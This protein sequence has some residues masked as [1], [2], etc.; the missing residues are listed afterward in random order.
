[1]ALEPREPTDRECDACAT[2]VQNAEEAWVA[3]WCSP[4]TA[5]LRS[6]MAVRFA[7]GRPAGLGPYFIVRF[8]PPPD[9]ISPFKSL[10][11]ISNDYFYD[12]PSDPYWAGIFRAQMAMLESTISTAARA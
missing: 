1:M 12:W 3:F 11:M 7:L 4:R 10:V 5:G 2:L 6:K 8:W 9:L